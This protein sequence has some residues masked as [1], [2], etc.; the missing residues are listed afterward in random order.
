MKIY[1]IHQSEGRRLWN[2]G[3]EKV[4]STKEKAREYLLKTYPN[5]SKC[6]IEQID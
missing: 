6:S 5:F 4:F 3:I 1:V 2:K